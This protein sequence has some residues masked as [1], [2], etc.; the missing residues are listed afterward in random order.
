MSFSEA[1]KPFPITVTVVYVRPMRGRTS[2]P[3]STV[4][5]AD[6]VL[7]V[8]LLSSVILMMWLPLQAGGTFK[9]HVSS[10][11][12]DMGILLSIIWSFQWMVAKRPERPLPLID[13]DV[14]TVPEVRDMVTL[15]AWTGIGNDRNNNGRRMVVKTENNSK[16]LECI[17]FVLQSPRSESKAKLPRVNLATDVIIGR[18]V[19]I[20]LEKKSNLALKTDI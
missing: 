20:A 14:P 17:N 7:P 15:A 11:V 9:L 4:N 19:Y 10:P 13:I 2:I 1:A 5:V 3:G 12:S 8:Q 6:A 16:L 18:I